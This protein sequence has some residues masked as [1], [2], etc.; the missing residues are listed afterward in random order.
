M[1]YFFC[2]DYSIINY[3]TLCFAMIIL[4][5]KFPCVMSNKISES[6]SE[7][8]CELIKRHML[9]MAKPCA[10]LG[11]FGGMPPPPQFFL[12]WCNLVRFGEYFDQ[13]LSL[14]NF[15]NYHFVYKNF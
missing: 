11:G 10:L 6:E 3:D 5:H 2:Y 8:Y 7:S 9:R 4:Y 12:K 14:K 15:K 1:C 13:I